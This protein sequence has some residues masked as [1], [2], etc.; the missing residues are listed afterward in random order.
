MAKAKHHIFH[1][2]SF[3]LVMLRELRL[4]P[5]VGG[6]KCDAF[7]SSLDRDPHPTCTRCRGKICTMDLTC[8]IC[9]EWSSAQ[10]EA[11]AKKRSYA[12][13]S[14]HALQPLFPLRRRLLP[15]C[16]LLRKSSTLRHP[17]LLLP[18]L[19]EGR[20]RGVSRDAPGAASHEA[21][22]P[23]A[24]LRS[25]GGMSLVARP[26]QASSLLPP[27]LLRE[28]GRGDLLVRSERPLPA[29][30]P[31][32]PLPTHHSTLCDVVSRESLRRCAPVLDPRVFPELR[33]EEQGRIVGPALSR[34]A[35]VTG[36]VDLAF[37]LLPACG[38]AVESVVGGSHLG[39]CPLA[40]GRGLRTATG[41]VVFVLTLGVTGR[42]LR[43]A[44]G[45]GD[46]AR[47]SLL[48]GEV[49]VTARGHAIPLAALVTACGHGC[50]RLPPLTTRGQR[51][52]D[53]KPD[54]RNR[55]VWRR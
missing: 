21:S 54:M 46:S 40:S 29:L 5:G 19:Q 20:L 37:A 24:R 13:G 38:Q 49:T 6:R 22:S 48:V 4:C 43:N 33:I 45:H 15:V 1:L 27:L 23:P 16:R 42:G 34:P 55:R 12:E 51:M 3:S 53:G 8:D 32:L 18:S 17:P 26:V 35:L 30:L 14:T 52:E 31:R 44:T 10:W 7:L 11:F 25:S 36:P 2:A 28:L 39:H 47:D 41:R 50:G 9:V